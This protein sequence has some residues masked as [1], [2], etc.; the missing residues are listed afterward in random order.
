MDGMSPEYGM[1]D[2]RKNERRRNVPR[3]RVCVHAWMGGIHNIP[4]L[5]L[6]GKFGKPCAGARVRGRAATRLG[7]LSCREPGI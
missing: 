1:T 2:P 4:E 5:E 6:D 7:S 3:H